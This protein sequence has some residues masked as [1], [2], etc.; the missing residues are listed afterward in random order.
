MSL[1]AMSLSAATITVLASEPGIKIEHLGTNNTIVRVDSDSKYL[2]LPVQESIDDATVKI[3]VDGK[4]ERTLAVRMAKSKVDY[5][6]PLDLTPYKGHDLILDVVTSQSRSSVR[7]AKTT[8]AGTTLHL[9][10]PSTQQTVRNI[11]R[12]IITHPS[13]DG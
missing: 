7:E 1:V 4:L 11:A 2:L 12:Y 6:V 9:L 8:P 13:T 3:I 10:T 5:T